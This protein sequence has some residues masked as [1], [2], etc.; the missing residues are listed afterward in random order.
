MSPHELLR[1]L[2][3]RR[4]R[5]F[6]D[7]EQLRVKGPQGAMTPEL[8][9]QLK[10]QKQAV[11]DF[12]RLG[13]QQTGSIGRRPTAAQ[14]ILTPQQE[15]QWFLHQE[16]GHAYHL[17]LG[18]QLAGPLRIRDLQHAWESVVARHEI[19]R[20]CYGTGDGEPQCWVVAQ[21]PTFGV[22]DLQGLDEP[23]QV[24]Q[25]FA[26]AHQ[27]RPFFLDREL[28]VRACLFILA[29][30]VYQ[31]H[32]VLHHICSDAESN[33]LLLSELARTYGQAETLLPGPILQYADYAFWQSQQLMERAETAKRWWRQHLA[34]AGPEQSF[35]GSK[36]RPDTLSPRGA[37]LPV[38]F[39]SQLTERIDAFTKNRGVSVYL[40][41]HT[42]FAALL[43]RHRENSPTVVG[44]LHSQRDQPELREM[45][46]FL[47]ETLPMV[48][49]T[50]D[51]PTFAQ[52][53]ARQQAE[54]L[55]IRTHRLPFDW[56]VRALERPRDPA[57]QP[58]F[59]TMFSLLDQAAFKPMA[60]GLTLTPLHLERDTAQFEVHLALTRSGSHWAGHW[61]YATDLYDGAMA[62]DH[63]HQFMTL[64]DGILHQPQRPLSSYPLLDEARRQ[65]LLHGVNQTHVPTPSMCLHEMFR[66]Q[67][68][69][70]PSA[71]ALCWE[72]EGERHQ[73]TYAELLRQVN[74]LSG[75]LRAR[76]VG[77]GSIV[78]LEARRWPFLVPSL[79]AVLEVG[80]AFLPLDTDQAAP[81]LQR[82]LD[83][84]GVSLLI[85]SSDSPCP[86]LR[87]NRLVP[88][89][90]PHALFFPPKVDP[91]APAYVIFTSGSSGNPKAV[92][93]PHRAAA[94]HMWWLQ[95][96]FPLDQD[97][98]LLHKTPLIFDASIW[99]I[100]HPLFSGAQLVLAPPQAHT[101]IA[102]LVQALCD[103]RI[104][105]L[106]VV[107]GYL[108]LLLGEPRLQ[109]ASHLR[110]LF[111]GGER[112]H[113]NLLQQLR[114]FLSCE[115]INFY[116]PTET[117]ID[118]SYRL[119][120][121]EGGDVPIGKPLDNTALYVVD[122]HHQP[123]PEY[124]PGH[125]LIGG[126]QLGQYLDQPSLTAQ[127]FVPNP[128]ATADAPADLG[129]GSRLYLSGDLVFRRRDGALVFLRRLDQQIKLHGIRLEPGEVEAALVVLAPVREAHVGLWQ[130]DQQTRLAAWYTSRDGRPVAALD[131]QLSQTLPRSMVPA[132]FVHLKEM[133]RGPG[134]KIQTSALPQPQLSLQQE[135]SFVPPV[136]KRESLIADIWADCLGLDRVGRHD[137]FFQLGGDSIIS[138][139]IQARIR[140]AGFQCSTRQLFLHQTVS[141]LAPL[142]EPCSATETSV[143]IQG[144]VP[145]TPIQRWFFAHDHGVPGHFNQ[146]I[147]LL[148]AD[149]VEP[150]NLK[151]ALSQM[152]R[153]HPSLGARFMRASE[154][155]LVVPEPL[156]HTYIDLR[157][158]ADVV[159]EISTVCAQAQ[160]SLDPGE[161]RVFRS[162]HFHTPAAMPDRLFLLAHHLVVDGVSWRI[163]LADLALCLE[164]G[165]PSK[166]PVSFNTYAAQLRPLEYPLWDGDAGTLATSQACVHRFGEECSQA[167]LHAPHG[168]ME[169][170]LIAA[171]V[172]ALQQS[173]ICL[174]VEGHGRNHPT[175]D[176][177]RTVGWMTTLQ[178]LHIRPFSGDARAALIAVRKARSRNTVSLVGLPVLFNFM[179]QTQKVMQQGPFIGEAPEE[180]GANRHAETRLSFPV[181]INGRMEEGTFQW[182]LRFSPCHIQPTQAELW[183]TRFEEA[184]QVLA[185]VAPSLPRFLCP[186]DT[187]V[188]ISNKQLEQLNNAGSVT[189]IYPLAPLQEGLLFHALLD[190]SD[191]IYHQ[192]LTAHLRGDLDVDRFRQAWDTLWQRH[193]VLRTNFLWYQC[194]QPLQFVRDSVPLPWS[195]HDLR[196]DSQPEVV[197]QELLKQDL[198]RP[199]TPDEGPLMR[200]YLVALP[201]ASYR[202]VWSHHH[203]ILD[204]WSAAQLVQELFQVYGDLEE[205]Q[206]PPHLAYGDYVRWL[207]GQPDG[208]EFWKTVLEGYQEP[209]RLHGEGHS[210]GGFGEYLQQ[211]SPQ[212]TQ[213]LAQQARNQRATMS[214]LVQL[215]WARVLGYHAGREDVVFGLTA[216][217]RPETLAYARHRIGLFLNTVPVRFQFAGNTPAYQLLAHQ[218]DIALAREAHLHSSL[219]RIHTQSEVPPGIPLFDTLFI[220]ENYPVE[221]AFQSLPPG[222]HL[223]Q[224]RLRERTNYPLV[225]MVNPGQQLSFKI[226][227][228]ARVIGR[229][230][231]TALV[232]RCLYLLRAFAEDV[233]QPIHSYPLVRRSER[234]QV[235]AE[236][237]AEPVPLAHSLLHAWVLDVAAQEPQR[238]ALM[239]TK[240][241]T[242][243]QTYGQLA[244][245]IYSLAAH[246][247]HRGVG[248][249]VPVA[250]CMERGLWLP[251]AMLAV[252]LAGGTF[253]PLDPRLPK[254]RQ[255]MILEDSGA[256]LV[257]THSKTPGL[258]HLETLCV[259][260]LDKR[261]LL[262]A[263]TPDAKNLAYIMFTSGSTGRPKGVQIT[264]R[265]IT[266]FLTGM[267]RTS[268]IQK[269]DRLLAV[270]PMSFDISLMEIF[271]PLVHGATTVIADDTTTTDPHQLIAAIEQY[272]ITV[273]EGTPATWQMLLDAEWQ[274]KPELCMISGGEALPQVLAVQLLVNGGQLLNL[275]GPTEVS[276]YNACASLTHAEPVHLG[277]SLVNT[278]TLVL[279]D[280]LQPVPAGV[281][282]E[283]YVAGHGL[284]RGY[285]GQPGLTAERFLP[286]PFTRE[287]GEPGARV[288]RVGDLGFRRHAGG[289]VFLGR[290]D[291]Q[292]KLRGFRIEPGEIEA[293]LLTI[294]VVTEAVVTLQQLK[295]GPALVAHFVASTHLENT[296]LR[297]HI[298]AR[299][300][301]YM[302]PAIFVSLEQLPRNA[303]QKIDRTALS[304]QPIDLEPVQLQPRTHTQQ[305]V[306]GIWTSLLQRDV[307]IHQNFFALGGHSLL[308]TRAVSRI[309]EVLNIQL[310]LRVFFE[311]PT[312]VD[313]C[314]WLECQRHKQE[315]TQPAPLHNVCRDGGTYELSFSQMRLW[316]LHQLEDLGA[317]YHMAMAL[318]L[319][320]PFA[321]QAAAAAL[322]SLVQR[323]RLLSTR[324]VQTASGEPLQL[325]DPKLRPQ[326][327]VVDLSGLPS[328]FREDLRQRLRL[329]E[330]ERSFLLEQGPLFRVVLVRE[331]PAQ[332]TALV[333]MHHIISDGWSLEL[334]A[335]DWSDLYRVHL[336]N[337]QS[338][339]PSLPFQYADVAH[340]QRL[341]LRDNVLARY[342]GYWQNQLWGAPSLLALPYDYPRP[343]EQS[344]AGSSYTFTIPTALM[345]SLS[346]LAQR[347]HTTLFMVLQ[348]AFSVLLCRYS[349]SRDI[350]MGTSL[351]NRTRRA[352][353]DLIGFF[354]NTLV[355][356][357]DLSGQGLLFSQLLE[358]VRPMILD[359]YHFQEMPFE[360]L[361]EMMRPERDLGFNPLVQV[362]FVLHPPAEQ[363]LDLPGIHISRLPAADPTTKFDLLL[364]IAQTDEG[365]KAYFQYATDLFRSA[366]IAA[367]TERFLQLLQTLSKDAEFPIHRWN[368]LTPDEQ[369]RLLRDLNQT[370]MDFD[371]VACLH[372]LFEA[373]AD[374]QPDAPALSYDKRTLSYRELER[375]ANRLAH[376]LMRLG[377]G[378]ERVVGICCRHSV[379]MVIGLLGITKAGGAYLPMSPETPNARLSAM[380]SDSHAQIL[381]TDADA[382]WDLLPEINRLNL[383]ELPLE[384]LPETRPVTDVCTHN[385]SYVIFTSGSTGAPKGIAIRHLGVVNNIL[386][387]NRNS[388]VDSQ[389]SVLAL[390][391]LSFDMC[392]YE[393]F[394]LLAAGGHIVLPT[395]E[396]WREPLAWAKLIVKHKV[397]VWNSAPAL[398]DM[399]MTAVEGKRELW[400]T[401]LRVAI[402]G[403]DWMPLTLP[404][405]IWDTAPRCSIYV[406]G[407]ATEAS[408][409]SLT[410]G[411]TQVEPHWRSIPYGTPMA[412]QTAW[413]LDA[414]LQP[415]PTG[416]PGQLFLGGIGLGRGYQGKPAMTAERFVPFDCDKAGARPQPGSRLY[417]TG[418]RAR[419]GPDGLVELLGRMDFQLKIRGFRV[420]AGEIEARL[421]DQTGVAAAVVVA[422]NDGA[423]AATQK[424]LVAFLVADGGDP[425]TKELTAVLS[426]DLPE[427]MLPGLYVVLEQFPLSPNGKVDRRALMERIPKQHQQHEESESALARLLATVWAQVLDVPTVGAEDHFF[428]LGGHSLSAVRVVSRL[429]ALLGLDLPVRVLFEAPTLRDL[430][431]RISQ[432]QG[433]PA[434]PTPQPQ[435]WANQTQP[436][437][438][439]Q[440]RLWFLQ[441]LNPTSNAYNIPLAM[442]LRGPLDVAL[443]AQAWMAVQKRHQVLRTSFSCSARAA[444]VDQIFET[445]LLDLYRCE[446]QMHTILHRVT[447]P[448][449][450]LDHPPLWRFVILRLKPQTHV[451][452]LTLHHLISDGWSTSILM[453]ELAQQYNQ[454]A[455]ELSPLPL[456]YADYA[457]WQRQWLCGHHLESL[458]DWWQDQLRDVPGFLD[459]PREVHTDTHPRGGTIPVVIGTDLGHQILERCQQTNT[460]PYMLL[461]AA[462][463]WLLGALADTEVVPL[464]TPY[465]SRNHPHLEGLVGFFVNTLVIPYRLEATNFPQLLQD[466]RTT[467]LAAYA[468]GE[469][470]FGQ[471]V[472]RLQPERDA[473]TNPLFQVMF[474]L[475]NTPRV[476]GRFPHLEAEA[477]QTPTG[478][479]RFHLNLALVQQDEGFS[480]TLEYRADCYNEAQVRQWMQWWT[481]LL[482]QVIKE[483]EARLSTALL[484]NESAR[485]HIWQ[486]A[487][488]AVVEIPTPCIHQR[489][490]AR[491]EDGDEAPAL[492]FGESVISYSQVLTKAQTL[493]SVLVMRGVLPDTV[494]GVHLPRSPQ[495]IIA[496]LAVL[497]AGGIWLPLEPDLP[498]QRLQQYVAESRAAWVI[499]EEEVALD[500]PVIAPETQGTSCT[501][502][503]LTGHHG[504]YVLFT[505]GSTGR[506]KGVLISHAALQNRLYWMQSQ[507]KLVPADRV[508]YKTPMGFD[509]SI[510]EWLWP[511]AEGAQVAIAPPNAHKEP[512][513]LARWMAKAEVTH[514]HFVPSMLGPFLETDKV[515]SL[516]Q[517]ISSGE[518]LSRAL[519][520]AFSDK[521][522]GTAQ[523]HNLYG[524]TEAA[525]DVSA[526]TTDLAGQGPVP[527]GRPIQN[528]QLYVLDAH[529]DLKPVGLVGDLYIGGKGLA[530][531]Y[532]NQPALTAASFVPNPFGESTRLYR[533]GDR[534][535]VNR[536]GELIFHGRN[537]TQLKLNGQR[538]EAG[539]IESALLTVPDITAAAVT[540]RHEPT[541]LVAWVQAP[542]DLKWSDVREHLS[543]R[544][545]TYMVP[546]IGMIMDTLPRL[547]SGKVDHKK[548]SAHPLEVAEERERTA[549]VTESLM[550]GL[551]QDL[552]QRETIPLN[553][554]FFHLGG[555]SLSA[556]RLAAR[557]RK[558]WH[559]EMALTTLFAHPHLDDLCAHLDG[560]A[561]LSMPLQRRT[562][563]GPWPL[564]FAQRRLWF[565]HDLEL[566]GG[567]YVIP[568]DLHMEGHLHLGAFEG[569]LTQLLGRHEILR[570]RL[571]YRDSNPM[572]QQWVVDYPPELKL[573]DLRGMPDVERQVQQHLIDAPMNTEGP[574]LRLHLLRMG[575]TRYRL[576]ACVHHLIADG[577]SMGVFARDFA[578]LYR[579]HLTGQ[580]PDLPDLPFTYA[581]FS[582]WQQACLPMVEEPLTQWWRQQLA[583]IPL[584]LDLPTDYPRPSRQSYRGA[585]TTFELSNRLTYALRTLSN[586]HTTTLFMTL[587][588]AFALLLS[589]LSEQDDM[590]MG[591][592]VA[593]R[594]HP[595]LEGV[596]GLFLNTLVLRTQVD[597]ESTFSDLLT[598][599]RKVH[600]EAHAHSQLPFEALVENLNC[601]RD[602][603][604]A[605]IFQVMM[606]WQNTPRHDLQLPG[607]DL[608]FSH[609][610][611]KGARYDLT[612][613]LTETQE[614]VEGRLVYNTDL[615]NEE[616]AST[617]VRRYVYLL[618]SLT[619]QPEL[620]LWQ[621]HLEEPQQLITQASN[622]VPPAGDLWSRFEAVAKAHPEA[623]A[624][625]EEGTGECYSYGQL[626]QRAASLA[627]TLRRQGVTLETSVGLWVHHHRDTATALLATSA[628][629]ATLVLLNAG[630]PPSRVNQKL[631]NS[632]TKLLLTTHPSPTFAPCLD[633]TQAL[634]P[635]NWVPRIFPAEAAAYLTYSSGS[636][637]EPKAA[638]IPRGALHNYLLAVTQQFP[639]TEADR[640]LHRTDSGF[641][642][643]FLE[644]GLPLLQGASI[645]VVSED[646]QADP[647]RLASLM[648]DSEVTVCK[649]V[650]SLL[651]ALL[652]EPAFPPKNLR[653]I[654]CGGEAMP[655][656]LARECHD[657][658]SVTLV[659]GYGLSEACI[660][661]TFDE[662]ADQP[663]LGST[664]SGMTTYIL[665]RWLRP[666]P[667][668]TQGQIYV[669][670]AGL[671]RAFLGE[672]TLTATRLLPDPFSAEP[673]TRMLA[674][675]D[676]AI[677]TGQ[678]FRF[679]GR[680]DHQIQLRGMR[681]EPGEIE[682][683]LRRHGGV[684]E[685]AVSLGENQILVAHVASRM[686][687]LDTADLQASL[688]QQLPAYMVPAQIILYEA[689]PKLPNGKLDRL[690]LKKPAQPRT[691]NRA[692]RHDEG[693]IQ[694]VWSEVLNLETVPLH[695]NFFD[696]GGHSLLAARTCARIREIFG[697]DLTTADFF[698]APT[699]E[700]QAQLL[701]HRGEAAL[702][703]LTYDTTDATEPQ[704]LSQAQQRLWFLAHLERESTAYHIPTILDLRGWLDADALARALKAVSHRQHCLRTRVVERDG[705]PYHEVDE[706]L[707][708]QLTLVDMADAAEE[709][710]HLLC[711]DLISARFDLA[712]GP[713]LRVTLL[714]LAPNHYRLVAVMHHIIFDAWSRS[715]F[716]RELNQAY[717][718]A[719]QESV[720]SL[721]PL[722]ISYGHY[723]A[724]QA[725]WLNQADAR[726][727]AFW[728]EQLEDAPARLVLY[729]DPKP[730]G[731]PQAD[732]I[733]FVLDE[734]L[735]AQL[736]RVA[737]THNTTLFGVLHGIFTLLLARYSGSGDVVVATPVANRPYSA[738]EQVIGYFVNLLPL[739]LRLDTLDG[740]Q[741]TATVAALLTHTRDV[742][743]ATHEHGHYPFEMLVEHL[744]LERNL[745]H[746]PVFQAM[747]IFHNTEGA[748]LELPGVQ[749]SGLRSGAPDAKV[750]LTLVM[751]QQT[752]DIQCTLEYRTDLFP[753][754]WAKQLSTHFTR[755][756]QA[757]GN[758]TGL[759][760]WRQPLMDPAEQAR[761][762]YGWQEGAPA[763]NSPI[764][765]V[766]DAATRHPEQVALREGTTT[767]TYGEL[768]NS[769]LAVASYLR[770]KGVG[771]ETPVA[772]WGARS[773]Q[774]VIALL[775]IVSAGAAYVPLNPAAPERHNSYLVQQSGAQLILAAEAQ[776]GMAKALQDSVIP[777]EVAATSPITYTP[778]VADQQSSLAILY[779]SGSTGRPKG[780]RLTHGAVG[781]RLAW[782]WQTFPYDADEVCCHKTSLMF[783]DAVAEIFEP[784]GKG[785]PLVIVDEA[786]AEN[787]NDFVRN[788]ASWGVTRL[789]LVPSLLQALIQS[790]PQ[791]GE[792]LPHLRRITCSGE[793]LTSVLA[794]RVKAAHPQLS[795][796]N[797]YG[798]TEVAADVSAHR[799]EATQN[800]Q[801]PI[802][803]PIAGVNLYLLDRFG[804]PVPP[805][806]V[807]TIFASGAGL[808]SGY[809]QRPAMTAASFVPDPLASTGSRAY[810]TGDRGIRKTEGSP[811]HYLG[812][813]DRCI[814]RNG[815]R[816]ELGEIEAAL[817]RHEGVAQA[818]VVA[819]RLP[820]GSRLIAF[821]GTAP[822]FRPAEDFV[823]QEESV[824]VLSEDA[825]ATHM[826]TLV[827]APM[828]PAAYVFPESFP[829][830]AS[831][832]I[833][834]TAL[835]NENAWKA[836]L[837][838]RTSKDRWT[839]PR[840]EVERVLVG[841]WEEVLH[842]YNVGITDRFF[843]LGGHSINAMQVVALCE[844][845]LD[846]KLPLNAIFS[847]PTIEALASRIRHPGQE[848]AWSPLNPFRVSGHKR[849]L[850]FVHTVGGYTI[851]YRE[852][853]RYLDPD[854]P[855]YGLQAKGLEAG[856]GHHSSIE[857]MAQCYLEAIRSVQLQGPYNLGGWSYG[858][859]ITF[860]MAHQLKELGEQVNLILVDSTCHLLNL[861]PKPL[862]DQAVV[863][864]RLMRRHRRLSLD[865]LDA[866]SEREQLEL[867]L[868]LAK[869][870][871]LF[872]IES[873]ED[874]ACVVAH[875]QR[876]P[877]LLHAYV[878]KPYA[879]KV[880]YIRA[881]DDVPE[882]TAPDTQGWEAHI[883][884]EIRLRTCPGSHSTIGYEPHVKDLGRLISEELDA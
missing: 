136:G 577:W 695:S 788:L 830:T 301:H 692:P 766:L 38:S 170:L 713:L 357:T 9:A 401:S 391:S 360:K 290:T 716:A 746:N 697:K 690:A 882:G 723:I 94:N 836:N 784:L 143:P 204:G 563:A 799:V 647:N 565:L 561:E 580:K 572:P 313:L 133:P 689:L 846:H 56:I 49:H 510:W 764:T 318:H 372:Q 181:E 743:L 424:D 306:A 532:V 641:D 439:E 765:A 25:L 338:A 13:E 805:G 722:P 661:V 853:A 222:L 241:A 554:H 175:L 71:T 348:A 845:R 573:M 593:H 349:G 200:L 477:L 818:V 521:Y 729:G 622:A 709:A 698:S 658:S 711:K 837:D 740:G 877:S 44:S 118:V 808:A 144:P 430:T 867:L 868:G 635:V 235:L 733:P 431:Q 696:L 46:G 165:I 149:T 518:C 194:E 416:V 361:V 316:L 95:R 519:V 732:R 134:G 121:G 123:Q 271:L 583:G 343:A 676:R 113:G 523:L 548:L 820:A 486:Q 278:A 537:D 508:A 11:L 390:S 367:L 474:A 879:G 584:C 541:S 39:S 179:G 298:S 270:T 754:Q 571:G 74:N 289:I 610:E 609:E 351:A 639:M 515:P 734:T 229:A 177:G 319:R 528:T 481:T 417:Q 441:T 865:E 90:L 527:I 172:L 725:R 797:Y 719:L 538:I 155:E 730:Q 180:T 291:H 324:F 250:I 619:E 473:H 533:T 253:V 875:L 214:T 255:Q 633:I 608:R 139:Q 613:F 321:V 205:P 770:Q 468:H 871:L 45:V 840:D 276:V 230:T 779:T 539:E 78:A 156:P 304:Q 344:F 142:L 643:V 815:I 685:A 782:A 221:S 236:L 252:N 340:W 57:R 224:V 618:E 292:I 93:V 366:T 574:L 83:S 838:L 442:L 24:A 798:S 705:K 720:F 569:A 757:F 440:E 796:Y 861:P 410:F 75:H 500:V 458:L 73:Q 707:E 567:G 495:Q 823:I 858:G 575:E 827:S 550:M 79:L 881:A 327:H 128:F 211:A 52:C 767:L 82:L 714:R 87:V 682:T 448:P 125:L 642:N 334:F 878:P 17:H 493:A 821:V 159:K 59:Q 305:V 552:L 530:H 326:A 174:V 670:G 850:F 662:V 883:S 679:T 756:L 140:A 103:F 686:P 378:P 459:L 628:C 411:V 62:Q 104:T 653:L 501:L 36:R 752:R 195:F 203:L 362:Y 869:D 69:R 465:A 168:R 365:G 415:V 549:T 20:T 88:D 516:R 738:L 810:A 111:C 182:H 503:R 202:F 70:T 621:H 261:S 237:M 547:S 737:R 667:Q 791:L 50:E 406:L 396:E 786:T 446:D 750:D 630:D 265:G 220:F 785:K 607:L 596:F 275:Y 616:T 329:R 239:V 296:A 651:E 545:P 485:S 773:M 138:M 499:S 277:Q 171:L 375:K 590:V 233:Q 99:E 760:I 67:V 589:K 544:L 352:F 706:A 295:T 433:R 751:Q 216:A 14:R 806:V 769:V 688:R 576:V 354:V 762:L 660:H 196:A 341:W 109:E 656:A 761:F 540:Y 652:D 487:Q 131:T 356:R 870:V 167:L 874:F 264:H 251:A 137:N 739:R 293:A 531:G 824:C 834:R 884:A 77:P 620:P 819:H 31:L 51:D 300:P 691:S 64:L 664:L 116:G 342:L 384:H 793:A 124:T 314:Q 443:L 76:G 435:R 700:E 657:N 114:K 333:T 604:F 147:L 364:D 197:F 650:P 422:R 98:R 102:A 331:Q 206:L 789:T 611:P 432:E 244:Q 148:L 842:T 281:P 702:P 603:S 322:A 817:M 420:E 258:S 65:H 238:T 427:Y 247:S 259:D 456:Q 579:S 654:I 744:E 614:Q 453:D 33:R 58:V 231:A 385:L 792:A 19:L 450:R 89:R 421:K 491:A 803:K 681:L 28:P 227:Y 192:Q 587:H 272:G 199:F 208:L 96:R 332:T 18:V 758:D 85:L 419:F 745:N 802:G 777:I 564:S 240:E 428:A 781:N 212:I 582:Q 158:T 273:M 644:I 542:V 393:I 566:A 492:L 32:L 704:P 66:Q 475:K 309:R 464:G 581:D 759:S 84:A 526:H 717:R 151:R 91:L 223:E 675:G 514:T 127:S 154:Q 234:A 409:H 588:A 605:P 379:F 595:D 801:Q 193:A 105:V 274:P 872:P 287:T 472:E 198:S 509:V 150:A 857:E 54:F 97:D 43:S 47:V 555:H 663:M 286:H 41:L 466:V 8:M 612:L 715:I 712:K 210:Q 146:S 669:S 219:T 775:G 299:L 398:M 551:W 7:G 61:I 21:K 161:G 263:P 649:L 345:Q 854:R 307:G 284:A 833:D 860:E 617:L 282:G 225:L 680:A 562:S 400:P 772:L 397:T 53:L 599:N 115:V 157:N 444:L 81:R 347:T 831:G 699:V 467:L 768:R 373:H 434:L 317:A 494:V 285:R 673:G 637:G 37:H 359:A 266:N 48:I 559:R 209:L 405:R 280:Q 839:P 330:Q 339:L 859:I 479:P 457:H 825:L 672:P 502:P 323:H 288:Y 383:Q 625:Y 2:H 42:V 392:V 776:M 328:K 597:H 659:N 727:V 624:I 724:Q 814:K 166:P 774:T 520:Q 626:H 710:I 346:E 668:G 160:E 570:T 811:L 68:A 794:A 302:V 353:E 407:G 623:P 117:A 755:L 283:I 394:G 721:P 753:R 454:P 634:D 213:A 640:M 162:I 835:A 771:M 718:H 377:V 35:P 748:L 404:Q 6:R 646:T 632:G 363:P 130:D 358:R 703:A 470:P 248:P 451:V 512:E 145:T 190:P 408:I 303:N 413:I 86:A 807:G 16:S 506:P 497:L 335:R 498:R 423:Q 60:D 787:L 683:V 297:S 843:E 336:L 201:D 119:W 747:T 23:H 15:T 80:A 395:S 735:T 437:S 176:L 126:A 513:E 5:I 402:F 368:I 249:E 399:L 546:S 728:Q 862:P 507:F 627:H 92:V 790:F 701:R 308:A 694:A 374:R 578:T 677:S 256:T 586:T 726:A 629:G 178:T 189:D 163:V 355:L 370:Q 429:S 471:L 511:L 598:K 543:Q 122:A 294:P 414:Q 215:A 310:P 260:L 557:I 325:V 847:N 403:G 615:F 741:P 40:F 72:V 191:Q 12:L 438:F 687:D 112:L 804:E 386:D 418:D 866:Y 482:Q 822:G 832:K 232:Q 26:L 849:P 55:E 135:E 29:P 478:Q 592:P 382:A 876:A 674:T 568:I 829:Q 445:A 262:S 848:M 120:D 529:M 602:P 855:F 460:T 153:H 226:S 183:L 312:L 185:L 600:L 480:G 34:G 489:F 188:A 841:I 100:C 780:V 809:H 483:P 684:R 129:P 517:V 254:Q 107:P 268:A 186:A 173:D 63:V 844:Q 522:G 169:D 645:C 243:H 678:G 556:A 749:V 30:Q 257:L 648:F 10:A 242:P 246:L 558:V 505:S 693:V 425:D 452:C 601:P 535:H 269:D 311:R 381:L 337:Q 863:L 164:G 4:I 534:A 455:A 828:L 636:T 141:Q 795:L 245:S 504:A 671:T 856:Q 447:Q 536:Q 3:S 665:D 524:P 267:S 187:G 800:S 461:S 816:M 736:Q 813:E 387:L 553:G 490:I 22:C 376:Y 594:P 585:A 463:A 106:Q 476:Q 449:F 217:H 350:L 666:A 388:P 436:L 525:I 731:H 606:V 852:L 152:V 864:R 560:Q 783:V 315:G 488:G 469:V 110:A 591:T 279:D 778:M 380:L 655:P 708:T 462:F 132:V 101:D 826:K 228:D 389:D 207:V 484:L 184:A 880:T 763:W 27:E 369:Q 496:K 108:P 638:V 812:R 371:Q 218:Q 873:V 320:G 851:D 1:A 742:L 412:N 426:Q 631:A